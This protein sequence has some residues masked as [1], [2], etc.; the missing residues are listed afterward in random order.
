MKRRENEEK[1]KIKVIKWGYFPFEVDTKRIQ[2]WKSVL[3]ETVGDITEHSPIKKLVNNEHHF[4]DKYLSSEFENSIEKTIKG[5]D[6]NFYFIIS[7]LKLENDWYSRILKENVVIFS[8]KPIIEILRNANIPIENAIIMMLYT[9]SLLFKK[10]N[11]IPDIEEETAF[12]HSDTRGCIFDM[13]PEPE[14]IIYSCVTPIICGECLKDIGHFP[15]K[16]L[17]N[18]SK[19]LKRIKKSYFHRI[20]EMIEY[21]PLLS[22]LF[23]IFLPISLAMLSNYFYR[24]LS[25]WVIWFIILIPFPIFLYLLYKTS[26]RK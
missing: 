7:N 12:L 16:L 6:N 1:I 3:F 14:E 20:V 11:K 24:N 23:A 18:V 22:G 26:R 9:Y 19:E 4:P 10:L 5:T 21:K 17:E 15:K 13:S 25:D 8:Y 2:S